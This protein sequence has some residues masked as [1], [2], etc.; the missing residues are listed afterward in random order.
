MGGLCVA[1]E[2]IGQY[3]KAIEHHKQALVISREID[4][5]MSEGKPP[6]DLGNAYGK[7]G[8]YEKAIEHYKQALVIYRDIIG[9]EGLQYAR[10]R[11]WRGS[12]RSRP[13]LTAMIDYAR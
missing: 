11:R 4:D 13:S 5:R 7:L 1:Y 12:S 6:G 9:E 8:H 10:R 2:S 3:E